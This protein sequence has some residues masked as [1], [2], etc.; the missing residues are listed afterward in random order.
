MV[1]MDAVLVRQVF[2]NLFENAV[3]YTPE[4]S[5]LEIEV[6]REGSSV[7]VEFRDLGP[8]IGGDDGDRLFERFYRGQAKKAGDGGAGLGLTICRAI[9]HAHGG[10]IAISNRGREGDGTLVRFTLPL[11]LAARG[12][13]S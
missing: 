5:P 8:G 10:T 6:T 7:A 12:I 9:V 1:P 3:R 2:V 11:P 4:G 13:S